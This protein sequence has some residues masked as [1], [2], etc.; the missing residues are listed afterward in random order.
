[1]KKVLLAFAVASVFAA[2]NDSK[3][4]STTAT[5]STNVKVDSSAI[6]PA[7]TDTLKVD[8]SASKMSADTTKK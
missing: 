5:D 7:V 2:C 8:S 6:T 1:M 3:T 4:D